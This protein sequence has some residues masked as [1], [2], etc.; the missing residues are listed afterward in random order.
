MLHAGSCMTD[1][2]DAGDKQVIDTLSRQMLHVSV[3]Q[4]YRIAGFL[5]GHILADADNLLA[6][7]L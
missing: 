5:L 3:K 7:F 1:G 2:T 4:L 6:A